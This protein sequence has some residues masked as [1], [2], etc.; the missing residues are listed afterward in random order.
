MP[1]TNSQTEKNLTTHVMFALR[2]RTP[3]NTIVVI[4]HFL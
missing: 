1:P 3:V 2:S 4:D